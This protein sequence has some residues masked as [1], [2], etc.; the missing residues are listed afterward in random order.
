M[1]TLVE[2][3]LAEHPRS[4]GFVCN[5]VAIDGID[6]NAPVIQHVCLRVMPLADAVLY[7]V[8][9]A[10]L[11]TRSVEHSAVGPEHVT[12]A[13]VLRPSAYVHVVQPILVLQDV[14]TPEADVILL[15]AIIHI[16]LAYRLSSPVSSSGAARSH[17]LEAVHVSSAHHQLLPF[18]RTLAFLYLSL[19][20]ARCN[21]AKYK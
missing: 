4:F 11:L 9:T 15:D 6:H 20:N 2:L 12:L 7:L 8:G 18:S 19:S 21:Y 13:A 10:Q 14:A 16:T 17:S 1:A 5:V 3:E